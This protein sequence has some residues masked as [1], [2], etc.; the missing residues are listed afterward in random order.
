MQ[1]E[2]T[3]TE[4]SKGEA[5]LLN[6]SR[7][8]NKRQS[9]IDVLK[10]ICA[11]L[12]VCIH[13]PFP[14]EIGE[15]I[16]SLSRIAVPVFF[17]ISGFFYQNT[18]DRHNERKQ[19][20][21]VFG[22]VIISTVIFLL[23][24]SFIH[25]FHGDLLAYW[26]SVFTFRNLVILIFTNDNPLAGHLW[27]LN[28][29]LYVLVIVY[30]TDKYGLK[31]LLYIVSPLLLIGDLVFGKYSILLLGKSFP[32]ILV[33]NFLFVGIPYFCIGRI[34]FDQRTKESLIK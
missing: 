2:K 7:A 20:K 1:I 32:F 10:A 3:A 25:F 19:I 27:Y 17:M 23:Y 31:K 29:V 18:A 22:L 21:K 4:T 34:I 24:Q 26:Q 15:Y 6:E 11:F 30:M 12:V 14:G 28:A 33:R 13:C 5:A 16:T 8:S 9:S